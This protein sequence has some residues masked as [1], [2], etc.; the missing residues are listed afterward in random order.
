MHNKTQNLS[1]LSS[2]VITSL[3]I[4]CSSNQPNKQTKLINEAKQSIAS[5]VNQTDQLATLEQPSLAE[6]TS[7]ETHDINRS[8][9]MAQKN[10]E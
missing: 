9:F 6:V 1:L 10:N 2:I 8:H 7:E 5:R 3:V 4:G